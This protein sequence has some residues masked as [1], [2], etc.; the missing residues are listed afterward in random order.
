MDKFLKQEGRVA[1]EGEEEELAGIYGVHRGCEDA[2]QSISLRGR[3]FHT[4][5][6]EQLAER[7]GVEGL[8]LDCS[9]GVCC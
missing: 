2:R 3:S 1:D 5:E 6:P 9:L 4:S 7:R 8:Q